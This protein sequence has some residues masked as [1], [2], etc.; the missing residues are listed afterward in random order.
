MEL[1][2][3]QF[4]ALQVIANWREGFLSASSIA[5]H[6]GVASESG[7]R[8]LLKPLEAKGLIERVELAKGLPKG[9]HITRAG[10]ELLGLVDEPPRVQ[11]IK[12]KRR[13]TTASVPVCCGPLAEEAT[14]A[15]YAAHPHADWREGDYYAYSKGDS[16]WDAARRIGIPIG[17]KTQMRP[18]IWPDDGDIVHIVL[19]HPDGR[20]E[21]TLKVFHQDHRTGA[22]TLQAINPKYPD[23]VLTAEK[24]ADESQ[25]E[26][27]G[28]ALE[29]AMPVRGFP[30][31]DR[32]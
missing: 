1:P 25:V 30:R 24:M 7:A 9:L 31:R 26:I 19:T 16:M 28:V 32:K 12:P 4:E 2:A 11:P 3:R 17:V 21:S 20:C 22:V 13:R 27:R 5:P 6:L 10:R 23:I 8:V 14:E 15:D 29:T 18:G